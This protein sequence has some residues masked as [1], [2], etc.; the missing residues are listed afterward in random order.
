MDARRFL[1][2]HFYY[3]SLREYVKK[4]AIAVVVL[5]VAVS[6]SGCL[7]GQPTASPLDGGESS[8]ST[9]DGEITAEVVSDAPPN[10]T[11]VD[12]G[13]DRVRANSYLREAV[14]EAVNESGRAV[15]TVPKSEVGK[16][17]A[18]RERLSG[19]FPDD[20]SSGEY[21]SGYYVEYDGT[22]VRVEFAVLN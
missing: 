3:I 20:D 8:A 19:Y 15:V 13:D 4:S 18:D 5:A 22:V 11:V 9:G 12:F 1:T 16:M 6:G 14:R 10:A 17:K 7:T 21:E 2:R